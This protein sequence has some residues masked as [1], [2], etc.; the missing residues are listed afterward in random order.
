[1]WFGVILAIIL[2]ILVGVALELTERALPQAQQEGMEAIIGALA[3]FFVTGMIIWMNTH[4]QH[5]R[6]Q[7]ESEAAQALS[8]TGAWALTSMAFLAVLKEG[9]ETSV[10]LLATFSA[11]QSAGLAAAGAIIGL[12]IATIIGWGIY[13][14]GVR[15]NLSRFFHFTGSF[16]ILVAAGLVISSLRS[17]HEGGW[18]NIGQQKAMDL[19]WMV[20]PGSI[21]SAL[22]TGVLGIPADPRVIEVTGWLIYLIL[23]VLFVYWPMAWRPRTHIAARLRF[24]TAGTLALIALGLFL[25]YPR[26]QLRLPEAMPLVNSTAQP[27]GTLQ[28]NMAASDASGELHIALQGGNTTVVPLPQAS[29]QRQQYA[30]ID[31]AVWTITQ[32]GAKPD[33][34][35]SITLEQVADLYGGRIP[36]G[37]NRQRNPG[38]FTANWS[39]HC[40]MTVWVADGIL[41]NAISNRNDV[42][43]LSGSH[44]QTPRTV[45]INHD[46]LSPVCRWRSSDAYQQQVV[47]AQN[48]AETLRQTRQFWALELPALLIIIALF[49]LFSASSMVRQQRRRSEITIANTIP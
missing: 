12:L 42:L 47:S 21:Q 34:P 7:L 25:F 26:P 46:D 19:S 9:F 11:A 40:V 37:L 49:F 27:V 35:T 4:A 8:H 39:T 18:L 30:G 32:R 28:L 24:I 43:T 31:A 5:M 10:F 1:M 36:I 22:V 2:S 41:L 16:L 38:P 48:Q 3:V 15:I 44:L 33:A 17:A 20:T 13:L 29:R 14:G 45:M 23:V 6:Q